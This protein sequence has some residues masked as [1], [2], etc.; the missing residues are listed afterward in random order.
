M[1]VGVLLLV[2]LSSMSG[3]TAAPMLFLGAFVLLV[4]EAIWIRQGGAAAVGFLS[5]PLVSVIK[6]G[7]SPVVSLWFLYSRT[8]R[9]RS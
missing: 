3:E 2:W 9:A 5:M 6:L 8:G 7:T 1:S 4:V